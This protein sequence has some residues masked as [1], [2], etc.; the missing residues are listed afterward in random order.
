MQYRNVHTNHYCYSFLMFIHFFGHSDYYHLS[1]N[2]YY[3]LG[4]HRNKDMIPI[5]LTVTKKTWYTC[6]IGIVTR[7][8]LFRLVGA[9]MIWIV[10]Y[11]ICSFGDNNCL[12]NLRR[13]STKNVDYTV[14]L[15]LLWK[16]LLTTLLYSV[17]IRRCMSE[18]PKLEVSLKGHRAT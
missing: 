15:L 4:E 7:N 6:M 12:Y 14:V 11:C 1:S 13:Y 8:D 2:I 17:T 3:L 18:L 16:S 10:N 9:Q 5:I